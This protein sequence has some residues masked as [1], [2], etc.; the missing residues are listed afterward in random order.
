MPNL[1]YKKEAFLK[2][3]HRYIPARMDRSSYKAV[4]E[5]DTLKQALDSNIYRRELERK[6]WAQLVCLKW[7]FAYADYPLMI[8]TVASLK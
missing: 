4:M 7:A 6:R 1:M 3:G 2:K 5:S 8:K